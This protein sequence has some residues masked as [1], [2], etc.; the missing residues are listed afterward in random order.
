MSCIAR[1]SG[2]QCRRTAQPRPSSNRL[3]IPIVDRRHRLEARSLSRHS[4][5]ARRNRLRPVASSHRWKIISTNGDQS[6]NSLA[7]GEFPGPFVSRCRTG[8][9]A[10]FSWSHQR[11]GSGRFREGGERL[12]PQPL[13][14]PPSHPRR[15]TPTG[16]RRSR[17]ESASR[18][19]AVAR[20]HN[21]FREGSTGSASSRSR[22][23]SFRGRQANRLNSISAMYSTNA[24]TSTA[25]G[26]HPIRGEPVAEVLHLDLLPPAQPGEAPAHVPVALRLGWL[27]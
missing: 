19:S 3:A 5:P 4:M 25:A 24:S 26:G 16:S 23:R 6:V 22:L 2:G 11:A 13:A 8:S 10:A 20:A 9:P 1:A 18:R 12:G 21:A 27:E 15:A 14:A 17:S 7:A